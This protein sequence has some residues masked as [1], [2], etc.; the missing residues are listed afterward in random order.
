MIERFAAELDGALYTLSGMSSIQQVLDNTDCIKNM[1]PLSEKEKEILFNSVDEYKKQGPLK[2][3]DYSIYQDICENGMPVADI[4]DAYNS[5]ML[6]VGRGLSVQCENGYYRGL[7]FLAGREVGKSWAE[8]MIQDKEG[9]DITE[10]FKTA[11][12]YLIQHTFL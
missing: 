10:L 4:L 6:Q 1:V 8:G 3:S 12:A 11:E 9:N 7:Q 2:R 5:I